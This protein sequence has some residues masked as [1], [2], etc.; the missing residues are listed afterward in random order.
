[1]DSC[2]QIEI[3]E[4]KVDV[5]DCHAPS[6][7]IPIFPYVVRSKIAGP[8]YINRDTFQFELVDDSSPSTEILISFSADRYLPDTV[9]YLCSITAFGVEYPWVLWIAD[10]G[11][12]LNC[13][14]II[15]WDERN[16]HEDTVSLVFINNCDGCECGYPADMHLEGRITTRDMLSIEKV[17][18]TLSASGQQTQTYTTLQDGQYRFSNLIFPKDYSI[19]PERNDNHKNG[20]TTSDLVRIQKHLLGIELLTIPEELIAADANNSW[21][22][23][24]ID[25][26]EIRKLILGIYTEFPNNPSW[27]FVPDEITTNSSGSGFNFIGIKIGDV[28]NTAQPN[29]NS[30]VHRAAMKSIFWNVNEIAYK[31]N[32]YINIDFYMSEEVDMEGFQFT[33]SDPNLEFVEASSSTIDLDEAHYAL[34]IDKMTFSW[35][36]ETGSKIKDGDILMRVKAKAKSDGYLSKSLTIN[37]EIT[38][39]EMYSS[40]GEIYSPKLVIAEKNESFFLA[41]EPNPWKESTMLHFTSLHEGEIEIEIFDLNGQSI[42]SQKVMC[43]KGQ[44]TIPL[45][46]V[47]FRSTGLLFYSFTSGSF[48]QSGK[49]FLLE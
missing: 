27:R 33:L 26:I 44:N 29:F 43:T 28:N 42:F 32:D 14:G 46:S 20:V 45:Q 31:T 24:A 19:K 21:N 37:S 7:P 4:N 13:D 35:F 48:S 25:L 16:I 22:V 23:S 6:H 10:A 41:V 15:E 1:M 40:G 2:G 39:A 5:Y 47:H 17:K 12:D 8:V 34:F 38:K 36:D 18:V 30:I 9:F 49:M 11:I 3:C